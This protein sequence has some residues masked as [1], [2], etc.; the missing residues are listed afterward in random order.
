LIADIALGGKERNNT[1][2][3]RERRKER[4]VIRVI[5]EERSKPQAPKKDAPPH[6]KKPAAATGK[7]KGV[8]KE[9]KSILQK[10]R[11][12][13]SQEQNEESRSRERE[14]ITRNERKK[15]SL[16]VAD[17][18]GWLHDKQ[19]RKKP[20]QKRERPRPFA[21]ER[22]DLRQ[23]KAA[24]RSE[25]RKARRY[26]KGKEWISPSPGGELEEGEEK[27]NMH[28]IIGSALQS[29]RAKYEADPRH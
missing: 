18:R 7:R 4:K 10:E 11:F 3:E 25:G 20:K 24:S 12:D 23:R 8:A 13:R 28:D 22:S 9:K 17:Q 27:K 21:R 19:K 29:T 2:A 5:F 14:E 26:I 15:S 6:E 16:I 1:N